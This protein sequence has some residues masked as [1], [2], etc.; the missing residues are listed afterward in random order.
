VSLV[1]GYRPAKA[2]KDL[3]EEEVDA[4]AIKTYIHR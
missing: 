1:K 3:D 4:M 2:D